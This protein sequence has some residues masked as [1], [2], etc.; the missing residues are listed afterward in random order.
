MHSSAATNIP[1]RNPKGV[2]AMFFLQLAN[3][4]GFMVIQAVL[5]LYVMQTFHMTDKPAYALFSAYI[6]MLFGMSIAGGYICELIGYRFAFVLGLISGTAGLLLLTLPGIFFLYLG[7]SVYIASTCISVTAMYVL[8]GRL[9]HSTDSRRDSGFTLAYVGSNVGAFIATVGA[10]YIGTDFSYTYAFVVGAAFNVL[11]LILFAFTH[12]YYHPDLAEKG[13]HKA[14]PVT[15]KTRIWGLIGFLAII[16]ALLFLLNRATLSNQLLIFIGLL[17]A[18]FI[19][20]TALREHGV[21]RAKLLV[22]WILLIVGVMFWALYMLAPSALNIF[23]DRNV[24]REVFGYVIPTVTVQ[25]LNPFFIMTLGP[26]LSLFWL[27]STKHKLLFTTPVKFAIGILLMGIGYLVLVP[28]IMSASAAGFIAI[29]W[30][31]LSYLLQTVG[32]LFVGPVGF[33]MVGDLVPPRMEGVMMGVWQLSTGV[34]GALSDY[35][36]NETVAPTGITQPLQTNPIFSHS[37]LQF[38]LMAVAVGILTALMAPKL[39]KIMLL[40]TTT[41]DAHPLSKKGSTG[42]A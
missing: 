32:E 11:G 42:D 6:A 23:V 18:L 13:D 38:G 36:A 4:V 25:S 35:L 19:V 31:V 1:S 10:G 33:A 41:D 27:H 2:G 30:I 17:S 8:L 34:A 22:Y 28:G 37:F 14:K 20:F 7:L 15:T 21:V 39:A 12:N 16:P 40:H 9:Y 3:M 29:S 5:V 24:N 26:L